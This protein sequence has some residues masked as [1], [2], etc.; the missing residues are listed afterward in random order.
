MRFGSWSEG[1]FKA[2]FWIVDVGYFANILVGVGLMLVFGHFFGQQAGK[3]ILLRNWNHFIIGP[4][5]G[6]VILFA[7]VFLASWMG[8]FQEGIGYKGS[9]WTLFF[10]Y[11][12][13]PVYWVMLFGALPV[14]FV[15]LWFGFRIREKGKAL[16]TK[17]E[18]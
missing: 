2:F 4:I 14:L 17:L 5:T 10:N 7:S 6:L 12:V 1:F 16:L 18:E 13:K 3:L 8:F 11:I 15:G 9:Y